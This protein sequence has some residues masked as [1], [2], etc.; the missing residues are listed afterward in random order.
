MVLYSD[1]T[2]PIFRMKLRLF[3]LAAA[4][5]LMT[6]CS[7]TNSPQKLADGTET[8]NRIIKVSLSN[9]KFSPNDIQV[10]KGEKVTLELKD[11]EGTHGIAIPGLGVSTGKMEPGQTLDIEIPTDTIGKYKFFCNVPCGE[12][13]ADMK[14]AITVTE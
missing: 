8:T 1:I 14:G 6:A 3:T 11:V 9:W 7:I 2:F 12:G 4:T 10:K 13:H 5:L